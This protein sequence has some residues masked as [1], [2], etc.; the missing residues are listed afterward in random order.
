MG[1]YKFGRRAGLS[2]K[3]ISMHNLIESVPLKNKVVETGQGIFYPGG[4]IP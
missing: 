3:E 1:N 2:V 4:L